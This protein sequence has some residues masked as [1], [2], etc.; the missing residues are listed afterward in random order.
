MDQG[1]SR[2]TEGAL[3]DIDKVKAVWLKL[4]GFTPSS[5][6]DHA[7]LVDTW[8]QPTPRVDAI[9]DEIDQAH[10]RGLGWDPR[11]KSW[12]EPKERQWEKPES[13]N[14]PF[15]RIDIYRDIFPGVEVVAPDT[16]EQRAA[17]EQV[18]ARWSRD[19]VGTWH[20]VDD[21]LKGCTDCA[22]EHIPKWRRGGKLV[23]ATYP[24][25]QKKWLCHYCGR[26]A[27]TVASY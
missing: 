23:Q 9:L 1:R 22:G 26:A 8:E 24:D 19:A 11:T 21:R 7:T 15:M 6:G 20:Q 16:V 3:I 12:G 18:A 10:E 25:G 13:S 4:C 2:Q 27:K 17:I 14:E 5:L